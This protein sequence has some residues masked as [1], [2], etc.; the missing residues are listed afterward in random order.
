VANLDEIGDDRIG[1]VWPIF[2]T[3]ALMMH[4]GGTIA[5]RQDILDRERRRLERRAMK[6]LAQ[7]LRLDPPS[8]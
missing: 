1:F 5:R 7:R 3:V 8:D 2:P 6:D 4:L